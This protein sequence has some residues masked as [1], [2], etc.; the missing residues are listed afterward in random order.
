MNRTFALLTASIF[1]CCQLGAQPRVSAGTVRVGIRV[2]TSA[3]PNR[4]IFSS[5]R[6]YLE[7]KPD[8]FAKSSSWSQIDQA[9]W[10]LYNLS[11]PWSHQSQ[12]G[13]PV[14]AVVIGIDPVRPERLDEFVVR[15]L[16]TTVDSATG[17]S[18]PVAL[19]RVY[20]VR[21][22]GRWVITNAFPYLTSGWPAA[23]VGRITYVF[24][25][26]HRFDE[27]RARRSARFVD[28]LAAIFEAE[29]R[30]AITYV[31]ADR[32]EELSRV[33][34]VDFAL[35]GTSNG[36]AMSANDMILSGLPIYGEFYP[37]EL[38]HLVLARLLYQLGTSFVF[39]EALAMY[40][41][42][43]RG[44]PFST[45]MAELPV[46]LASRPGVALR[47][48]L[49]AGGPQDSVAFLAAAALIGLTAERIGRPA[50]KA[51]LTPTKTSR[52]ADHWLK[53]EQVLGLRA[54]EL[55]S[56]VRN[57]ARRTAR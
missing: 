42:G 22:A 19:T 8:G 16:F 26:T 1:C 36:R 46:L 41:G 11:Y 20:A 17:M 10:P 27:E 7:S 47:D 31:V 37:H 48:L 32:P 33:L 34:G 2:D 3:T 44:K 23:K 25:P 55:D 40:V 35:P 24:S 30:P 29:P 15:T 54:A 4:E 53:A 6:A 57:F 50:V 21:E 28:S 49:G 18:R 52:G 14:D 38:T 56:A 45:L 13:L 5:W 51:L 43:S 12:P 9:R 39:D